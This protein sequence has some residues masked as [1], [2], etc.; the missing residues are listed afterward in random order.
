MDNREENNRTVEQEKTE[1]LTEKTANI[2]VGTETAETK[3]EQRKRQKAEKKK[4]AAAQG[5]SLM[6]ST[7][8]KVVTFLLM[9]ATAVVG[10]LGLYGT[11]M[12][13]D[14]GA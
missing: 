7:L 11:F 13:A 3:K 12:L 5:D 4:K 1:K 8:A 9:I 6:G 14:N 10:V 2:T